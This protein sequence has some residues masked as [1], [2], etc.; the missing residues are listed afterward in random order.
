MSGDYR[1]SR[2]DKL[3][4][5]WIPIYFRGRNNQGQIGVTLCPGKYQPQ[6]MS[7]GWN[8]DLELDVRELN[9]PK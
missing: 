2:T 8:R 7:G 6:S 3:Q 1:N 5:T 9:T 4:I